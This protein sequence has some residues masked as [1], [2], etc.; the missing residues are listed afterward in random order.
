MK[1]L[2]GTEKRYEKYLLDVIKKYQ[3]I[4]LLDSFTFS[5]QK[6]TQKQNSYFDINS[7]HPYLTPCIGWS[8][9]SFEDW[10]KKEEPTENYVIHELSHVIVEPLWDAAALRYTTPVELENLAERLV[11]HIAQIVIKNNL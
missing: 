1:K 10:K 5:V 4:L 7:N 9:R 3:K 8:E 6:G 11:D 2:S